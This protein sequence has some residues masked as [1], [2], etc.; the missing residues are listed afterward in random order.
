[1]STEK[2]TMTVLQAENVALQERITDLEQAMVAADQHLGLFR[3]L[4]EQSSEPM[5]VLEE[6]YFTECNQATLE[7]FGGHCKEEIIGLSPIALSPER[8]PDGRFSHEKAQEMITTA[9]QRGSVRFE[10]VHTFLDGTLFPAEIFLNVIPLG[11]KPIIYGSWRDIS[12]QK[13]LQQELHWQVQLF[14]N[15][16]NNLPF[17]IFYKDVAGVYIG[18]NEHFSRAVFGKSKPDVVGKTVYDLLPRESADFYHQVDEAALQQGGLQVYEKDVRYHDGSEHAI[19]FHKSVFCNLDGTAGGLIGTMVD[20]SE[21]K[22]AAAESAALQQQVI[23]AQ[24]QAL[25]ELSTPLIPIADTV[26]IMPLIGAIDKQRAQHMQETLLQ[27]VAAH[28]VDTAILD[29]TGVKVIDTQVANAFVQTA[30][31][32]RLLGAQVVL[33]G[34]Q[35]AIA[36]TLVTLGVDLGD[37]VTFG[38]LQAGIAYALRVPALL[39][40]ARQRALG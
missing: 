18:C 33:T 1:M 25:R 16:I 24:Q 28:H 22:R 6:G 39:D 11:G 21:Q 9:F 31:A 14:N 17:P 20:I 35:P 3:L 23:D 2:A 12:E 8:Q 40:T 27:G 37:L 30:Q 13:Q 36:Q 15:L 26:V 34:I 10:W 19:I 5:F 29:I 38:S 4:Y 32:V 7:L